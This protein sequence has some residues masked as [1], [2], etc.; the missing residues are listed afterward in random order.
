MK[1]LIG[2]VLIIAL[3]LGV[4]FGGNVDG[5]RAV[6]HKGG[7]FGADEVSPGHY[8]I[9]KSP[10]DLEAY[11]RN[12]V[13]HFSLDNAVV[14]PGYYE[15]LQAQIRDFYSKFD[16]N[17]FKTRTLVIA[18]VDQGSGSVKYETGG[19]EMNGGILTVNVLRNAGM[20]QTMDFVRWV[21]LLELDKAVY[22]NV[23]EVKIN[24]VN[25]GHI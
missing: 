8:V 9:I 18:L 4:G 17:F 3:I 15:G 13:G 5:Y 16:S 23:T 7:F 21:L 25:T 6:I 19:L 24:L 22:P 20:I 10:E 1:I 14:P 12:M 2:C 11:I